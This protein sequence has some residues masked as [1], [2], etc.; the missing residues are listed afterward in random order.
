V[1]SVEEGQTFGMEVDITE[2]MQ[3]ENGYVSPYMVSNN[4]KMTAEMKDV[5]ILITDKKISSTKDFL[6]LLEELVNNGKK[7]LVII[8]DDIEGEALT[9]IILNK[10][11]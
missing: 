11:K 1:I 10:L 4:E 9:T 2:G 5:P 8:A 6:P 7:D 3:F